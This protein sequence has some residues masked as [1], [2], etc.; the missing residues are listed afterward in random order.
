MVIIHGISDQ[1]RL[2]LAGTRSAG[3]CTLQDVIVLNGHIPEMLAA[4]EA[5]ER[6][7][8]DARLQDLLDRAQ[9]LKAVM[10]G[11]TFFKRL[12]FK[13]KAW[14]IMVEHGWVDRH[15]ESFVRRATADLRASR[16]FLIANAA[17]IP[18]ARGEEAVIG[19][20][21]ALPDT[22]YVHNNVRID[23]GRAAYNKKL[24]EY[25]RSAQIDHAVVGPT[26]LFLLE[27]KNWSEETYRTRWSE[28][29]R[30][31]DRAGFVT[32]VALARAFRDK[33]P[34][35]SVVVTTRPMPHITFNYVKQV[36]VG[37]LVAL[38]TSRRVSMRDQDVATVSGWL[39]RYSW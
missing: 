31:A 32:W 36:D 23:L 7:R 16:D 9:S 12:S 6:A 22:Y 15:R 38:I 25:N 2:L 30:Q 19:A 21:L 13:F 11:A 4:A 33:V 3:T 28:P 37:G 10:A 34:F 27:T 26:G 20:L 29:H 5:A 24:G 14:R 17:S 8:V 1:T 35:T 39:A 18:G